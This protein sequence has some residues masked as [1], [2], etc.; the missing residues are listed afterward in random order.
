MLHRLDDETL[1][2]GT[3][4]KKRI[5]IGGYDAGAVIDISP[6][7][8]RFNGYYSMNGKRYINL[9]E[10]VSITWTDLEIFKEKAH[11]KTREKVSKGETIPITKKELTKLPK[12]TLNG[13]KYY[14]D[15]SSK[16]IRRVDRPD[17]AYP[18][19]S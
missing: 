17:V 1:K 4:V 2:K 19:T 5:Q 8:I 11:K 9:R 18:F 16:Q 7:G 10:G 6:E 3:R 15:V 13:I 12:V 14:V